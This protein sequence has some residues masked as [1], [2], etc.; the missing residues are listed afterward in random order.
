LVFGVIS[1]PTSVFGVVSDPTSGL[2]VVSDPEKTIVGLGDEPDSRLFYNPGK[3]PNSVLRVVFDHKPGLTGVP[4]PTSGLAGLP[5]PTSVLGVV[6]DPT[7]GLGVVS[8]PEKSTISDL[9]KS[10]DG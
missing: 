4:D 7:S 6:S 10:M 3:Q 5:D 8:D 9:E 2:G 1:D